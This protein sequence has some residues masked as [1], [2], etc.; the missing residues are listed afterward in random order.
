MNSR[1]DFDKDLRF[2]Q[3]GENWLVALANEGTMEM[4]RERAYWYNHNGNI[5]FEYRYRGQLSG[6]STTKATW[7][8]HIL[9]RDGVNRGA[10]VL[11]VATLRVRLRALL[12]ENIARRA[13][14]GDDNQSS[15]ILVPLAKAHLLFDTSCHN[16]EPPDFGS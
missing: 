13:V 12:D 3:E 1:A 11:P 8:C 9:S 15:L 14:G 2:G 5:C 10:L 7:W 6:I 4:K 16:T